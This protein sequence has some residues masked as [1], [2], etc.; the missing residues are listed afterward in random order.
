MNDSYP[1]NEKTTPIEVLML[2]S[3]HMAVEADLVIIKITCK[4]GLVMVQYHLLLI[5]LV[6]LSTLIFH[7]TL[8]MITVY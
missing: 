7:E 1:I 2:D 5:L 4:Y 6:N 8:T 3:I